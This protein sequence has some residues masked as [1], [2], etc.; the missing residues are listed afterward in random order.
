LALTRIEYGTFTLKKELYPIETII[1]N[2]LDQGHMRSLKQGRLIEMLVPDEVSAVELDPDLIGQVFT[3]LIENAI[4][5]TPA[6]SPIEISVRADHEQVLVTVADRGPGIPEDALE[7]VFERFR[8]VKQGIPDN[9]TPPAQQGS[10]LGLA[11]CRGFVQA[12]RGRIWAENRKDGGAKFTFTLPLHEAE[13]EPD[14]KD[15]A[16]RG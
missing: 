13:G 4:R 8:R 12:H 3:N 7:L 15:I 6:E 10:G 5:Y 14:E 16:S 9:V 11:I 2:A 1:L